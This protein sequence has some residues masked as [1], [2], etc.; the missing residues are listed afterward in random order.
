[1]S[2]RREFPSFF[3]AGFECSSHRRADLRR[4]DLLAATRHDVL[5]E[6]DYRTV[7][8]LGLST[9]RDGVR[10]HL[11]EPVPGVYDWASVLP[12]IRASRDLGL[13]V[14]WDLCHYGWP[15]GLDIWSARFVDRF[16][17]FAAAFAEL[18]RNE[19]LTAPVYCPVNEISYWAWAGADV[20][21]INPFA[22]GRGNELKRQLV[23]AAL[24]GIDAVRA[25][26]PAARIITAEPL[27]NID[28]GLSPP[29][30]AASA[31]IYHAAQFEALDMLVGR[32]APEL[33]GWQDA[34][35]VIGLNYYPE[36]QWYW[37]GATIPLGHHA[38]RPLHALLADVHH[39][40]GRPLIVSETG[41]EGSGRA[42]WLHYVAGE[43]RAAI[44]A[45]TPVEGICLYPV[46]D[47]PGWDNDR[48]CMVGLLSEPDAAGR[49]TVCRRFADE[50]AHQQMLFESGGRAPH[51]VLGPRPLESVA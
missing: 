11:A 15:D 33:G 29:E 51:P 13:T 43:V 23:R 18:L 35:D 45:G 14:A 47:Y 38:Y 9:V 4:L 3:W 40:Y 21:R 12:A 7:T 44:A 25:V 31:A 42:S 24:A 50:L 5:V 46:V 1:M 26:D 10:W 37:Q 36:N 8:A 6:R 49:R 39:R 2:K 32:A 20:G 19:G 22:A 16:G 17:R 27:V 30:E 28:P 41:A 48:S 34:L